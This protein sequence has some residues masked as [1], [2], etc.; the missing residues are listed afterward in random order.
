MPRDPPA[1]GAVADGGSRGRGAI[2]PI[3]GF[4]WNNNI[5]IDGKVHETFPNFNRISPGYFSAMQTPVVAGRDF[6]FS[7]S[8][9]APGVAIVNESFA[10]RFFGSLNV[11]GRTFQIEEPVGAPRPH[12][13]IVGIRSWASSRTRSIRICVK[14]WGQSA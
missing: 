5:L 7:D 4:M 13:Q 11:V 14:R 6:A 3:T 10:G 1:R 8:T 9:G 2:V 12:Y